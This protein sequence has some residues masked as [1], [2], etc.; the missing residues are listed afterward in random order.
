MS[1]GSIS[2]YSLYAYLQGDFA[3]ALEVLRTQKAFLYDPEF[4][5]Y[6][7]RQ[8]A[9][10]DAIDLANEL[11]LRSVEEGY[12]SPISIE[13]DPWLDSLRSTNGYRQALD[14]AITREAHARAAFVEAGGER[15]LCC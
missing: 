6:L 3:T 2:I 7:A 5:F 4:R 13:R 10:L 1:T 12:Y 9:R 8:A 14:L 11:L 15:I